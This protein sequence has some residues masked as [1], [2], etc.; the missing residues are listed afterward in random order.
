MK[1]SLKNTQSLFIKLIL[2]KEY[3]IGTAW[4][5]WLCVWT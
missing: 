2:W 3:P 1:L 5:L 4:L